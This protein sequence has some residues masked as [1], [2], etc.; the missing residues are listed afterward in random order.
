MKIVF[1]V[2]FYFPHLGGAEKLFARIAEFLARRGWEV[3]VITQK[4]P[5][6]TSEETRKKVKIR[7]VFSPLGRL[8][9]AFW[10]IPTVLFESRDA[11]L[12]HAS[13]YSAAF[14]AW[15]VGKL[16]RKPVLVTV[17]EIFGRMWSTVM[18]QGVLRGTFYQIW[19]SFLV[20]LGFDLYIVPSLYTYNSLR[21]Y[22]GIPDRKIR[23]LYHGV[24]KVF[25]KAAQK[26]VNRQALRKT[27]GL[28]EFDFLY[29]FF[30]RPGISKG[31]N[32][33][34]QAVPY[35]RKKIPNSRL[36]LILADSPERE[37]RKIC[38]KVKKLGG[39]DIILLKPMLRQKLIQYLQAVDCVVIPSLA[40]GFGFAAA[41]SCAL[42]RPVVVSRVASLPE[43][44]GG[45]AVF[46]KP[47]DPV[48]IA[49]GVIKMAK[50]KWQKL[51]LPQ[52]DWFS[53]LK[54]Y[55][56]LYRRIIK[57]FARWKC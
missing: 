56:R 7:R 2:D 19:E 20:G 4:L 29:L 14:P 34:L 44:V 1:V 15:L 17:H 46:A 47:A 53:V 51:P 41:E 9:F 24:D 21:L 22:K 5:G 37:Y 18:G 39:K 54:K 31:V 13:L 57:E 23:L 43:V 52:F 26:K 50:G 35:I 28:P 48:S 12:I 11:D 25:Y 3:V 16:L 38:Q 10:A 6:T 49:R 45:K 32:Y 30:G 36:V 33:L 40:E 42:Q 27:L 8:G 55:E